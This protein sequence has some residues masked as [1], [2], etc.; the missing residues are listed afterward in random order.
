VGQGPGK[1][2][3]SADVSSTERLPPFRIVCGALCYR[4]GWLPNA[5][6]D[7]GVDDILTLWQILK[8]ES[9]DSKGRPLEEAPEFGR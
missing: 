8:T 5:I 2:S 3:D 4:K 1:P 9:E 6:Q 7:Q